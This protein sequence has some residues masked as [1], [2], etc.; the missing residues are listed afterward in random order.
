MKPLKIISV[1]SLILLLIFLFTDPR[2]LPSIAL[3][4][5][6]LLLFIVLSLIIAFVAGKS[7]L[8]PNKRL[9]IGLIGSGIP[10]LL[11]VLQSLGQLTFRD[12]LAIFALFGIAYFYIARFGIQTA[13]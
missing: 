1:A 4:V 13:S 10:V 2:S 5:P 11:L 6:F 3:I 8:S 12:T 7:G 9:R